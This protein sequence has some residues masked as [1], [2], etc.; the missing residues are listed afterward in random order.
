MM[1]LII[2]HF[3]KSLKMKKAAYSLLLLFF[4]TSCADQAKTVSI[5][6]Y[7]IEQFYKNKAISGGQFSSDA[8]QL[9]VSS[10]ESGI[11]NVYALPVDGSSPIQLTKS[12]VESN[13]AVSFIPNSKNFIFS[14]DKGGDENSRLY[15]SNGDGTEKDLTPF[16][17]SSNSFFGWADDDQSFFFSSNKRDPRFFDVYEMNISEL[18]KE[19]PSA[20][21]F[22]QNNDGLDAALISH[23]KRYVILTR[24]ITTTDN[25]MML[26]DR[27]SG[28]TTELTPHEEEATYSPQF[29]SKDDQF[30]YYLTNEGNE[31]TYLVKLNL[32]TGEK[33]TV[34]K[35][36]W[37]IWYAYESKNGK[38]R[39]AGV[40]EDASTRI[41][42]TETATGNNVSLPEIKDGDITSVSISRD[43]K[44]IRLTVGTST[45]PSNIYV[46]N[47][48]TRELK[49]I[50]ET[51]NPEIKEE[52]LVQGKVIRYKSFDG[53]EIPSIYYEPKTA[54][55]GNKVPALVWVHGG[56]GG[57]SRVGYSSLIQYLV[58][59]GYAVLAV[60]NRGSDGYGKTFFTMDDQKHGDVDL[61]DCIEAKKFLISTGV[62]DENKIGIIG[63][64]YGGYMTMAALSFAPEEFAVG[65][66][67]FG[68]TNWL[69]T[70]K[71]IPPY[72]ESFKKAL[73]KEMGDP[74]TADSVRLYNISPVFHA[75]NVTKPLM[76]LQGANDVRVLKVESDEIVEGVKANG[77]PV[78]YV[79]FDDEGHGFLKKENEIEG[80]G[81]V[82]TFLDKYLK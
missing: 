43:E 75:S 70:L 35:K 64:S 57:Q 42:I 49:K 18:E 29:F 54:T 34:F 24:T 11:F 23:N 30:L 2:V 14:A 7:S 25:Q 47:F 66:N 48:D 82:K 41:Y 65:V 1:Q 28:T 32:S 33:E 58:N 6:K 51:L 26:H 68:V 61:K 71:S 46:Y 3:F 27:E 36:D 12:S 59:H 19:K 55:A 62:I 56:P 77:V 67:I 38:Y 21:I 81:K 10:N 73:Y 44:L 72:W 78:E 15:F 4:F 76:V 8:S 20:K 37:D 50:T 39:V 9:L 17:K 5:E 16:E 40:N 13:F 52:H 45:S 63:G 79:V 69:R 31:F 53:L 80:Y 22:Y 60:N 74:Y